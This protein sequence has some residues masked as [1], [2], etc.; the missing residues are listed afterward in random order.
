MPADGQLFLGINDDEVSDN[1]GEFSSTCHE[2]PPVGSTD[3]SEPDAHRTLAHG[4]GVCP[5]FPLHSSPC[6]P[7]SLSPPSSSRTTASC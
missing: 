4:V 7:S 5:V 6:P 3:A 1:R 2:Q